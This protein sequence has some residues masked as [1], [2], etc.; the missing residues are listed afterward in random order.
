[1]MMNN[2]NMNLVIIVPNPIRYRLD[3]LLSLRFTKDSASGKD[4]EG[5]ELLSKN[6]YFLM[7]ND[8]G[9]S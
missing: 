4:W 9:S 5:G 2:I 8:K 1:M 6:K 3:D 7:I